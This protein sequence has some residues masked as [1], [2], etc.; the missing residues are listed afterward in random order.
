MEKGKRL[1]LAE[2]RLEVENIKCRWMVA[3]WL[4]MATLLTAI[5]VGGVLFEP[6]IFVALCMYIPALGGLIWSCATEDGPY[7][8]RR[9]A[10]WRVEDLREEAS[11]EIVRN[12]T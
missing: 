10:R 12:F 6:A 2:R 9:N 8:Q 3:V 5:V 4:L 7:G 11:E 1:K